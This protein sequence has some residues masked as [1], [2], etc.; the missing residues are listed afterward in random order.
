MLFNQKSPD[1]AVPGHVQWHKGTHTSITTCKLIRTMVQFSELWHLVIA[2]LHT[3]LSKY[4]TALDTRV[5]LTLTKN[6]RTLARHGNLLS[7]QSQFTMQ[8][9]CYFLSLMLS[10]LIIKLDI[11]LSWGIQT[12]FFFC[13]AKQKNRGFQVWSLLIHG[14]KLYQFH[15][16]LLFKIFT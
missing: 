8:V 14:N 16:H 10:K 1:Y 12:L 13:K 5:R 4:L 2:A 6:C 3:G 9:I 11:A 7:F 15:H